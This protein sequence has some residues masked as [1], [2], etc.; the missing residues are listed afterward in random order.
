M[1]KN[2]LSKPCDICGAKIERWNEEYLPWKDHY[3]CEACVDM[4]LV[5]RKW[6]YDDKRYSNQENVEP[7][8]I[9]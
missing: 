6:R 1:S 3:F 8:K 2:L 9:K 4:A 5:V 7:D